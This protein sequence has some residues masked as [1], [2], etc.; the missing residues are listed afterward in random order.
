MRTWLVILRKE[1]NMTQAEL[2]RRVGISQPSLFAIE[3]GHNAPKPE[4]AKR[5][6]EILG[7]PWTRFYDN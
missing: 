7:F 6:A 1:K 2:A 3:R 4:N 5:I